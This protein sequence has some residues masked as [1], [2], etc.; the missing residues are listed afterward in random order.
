MNIYLLIV[1]LFGLCFCVFA[2]L[3]LAE[4]AS[5]TAARW[6]KWWMD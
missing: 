2:A 5:R 4:R 3:W 6:W 1:A